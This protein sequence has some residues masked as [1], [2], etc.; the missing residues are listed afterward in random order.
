MKRSRITRITI[1]GKTSVRTL[2]RPR[3]NRTRQAVSDLPAARL[4]NVAAIPFLGATS[5]T[6]SPHPFSSTGRTRNGPVQQVHRSGVCVLR[7][8][9][10]LRCGHRTARGASRFLR[11]PRNTAA[12]KTD[13]YPEL[14]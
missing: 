13:R 3:S 9:L 2:Y 11:P 7:E 8:N 5:R 14:R 10:R 6:F 1:L 12:S 4:P